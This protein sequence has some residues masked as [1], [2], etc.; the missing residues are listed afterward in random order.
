[1]LFWDSE[2]DLPIVD[3]VLLQLRKQNVAV[4]PMSTILP[5][6]PADE[7]R[8]EISPYDRHPNSMA[9]ETIADFVAQSLVQKSP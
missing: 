7:R 8:Y 6:F 5:N 4:Y 3:Q 2:D 9:H 1:V